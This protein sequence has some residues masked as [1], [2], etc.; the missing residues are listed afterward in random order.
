MAASCGDGATP[1][2]ATDSTAKADAKTDD[3]QPPEPHT[4]PDEICQHFCPWHSDGLSSSE[5]AKSSGANSGSANTTS[6][7]VAGV[8]G[9]IAGD[10]ALNQTPFANEESP[11]FVASFAPAPA[12]PRAFLRRPT[13]FHQIRMRILAAAIN[14]PADSAS[15]LKDKEE[16]EWKLLPEGWNFHAQTTI[17]EISNPDS[18]PRTPVPTAWARPDRSRGNDYRGPFSRRAVM[19]G[20]RVSRGF[21]D[22][23]GLRPE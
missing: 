13:R 22:V 19:A 15:G 16:E 1:T 3:K 21:A 17:I 23:A 2:P 6:T 9:T 10:A 14:L 12:A 18:V 7:P 11:S 4:W 20:C 8:T 5:P